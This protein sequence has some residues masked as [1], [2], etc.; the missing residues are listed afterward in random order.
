MALDP[1]DDGF[2][3]SIHLFITLPKETTQQGPTTHRQPFCCAFCCVDPYLMDL[4]AELN[5]TKR[6]LGDVFGRQLQVGGLGTAP[7]PRT[8][9]NKCSAL[10]YVVRPQY[11]T[12]C[13]KINTYRDTVNK[14]EHINS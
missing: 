8:S 9:Q 12:I 4:L 1:F 5:A 11:D 14:I 10:G 3:A 7:I 2:L 6:A 13:S